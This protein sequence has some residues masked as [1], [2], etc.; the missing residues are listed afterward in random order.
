MERLNAATVGI[1]LYN[2]CLI[3]WKY[4]YDLNIQMHNISI[5]KYVSFHLFLEP[6]NA[7]SAL[8][9]NFHL[10]I[11]ACYILRKHR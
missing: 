11:T 1:I 10:K 7:D 6:S 9:G 3:S 5:D 4:K 2:V 8:S